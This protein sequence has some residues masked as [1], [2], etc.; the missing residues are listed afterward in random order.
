MLLSKGGF[1]FLIASTVFNVVEES[2]SIFEQEIDHD[3]HKYFHAK[4]KK[5]KKEDFEYESSHKLF[6]HF[7][8]RN[9]HIVFIMCRDLAE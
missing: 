7:T 3:S 1:L 5:A 2:Q 6:G 4:D 8:Y 9:I